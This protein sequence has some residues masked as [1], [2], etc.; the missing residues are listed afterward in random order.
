M[1]QVRKVSVNS[2]DRTH[3][4]PRYAADDEVAPAGQD[5]FGHDAVV[6]YIFGARDEGA[7]L[8]RDHDARLR[9][10]SK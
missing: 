4:G 7:C 2:R 3:R 1:G 9:S 5:R 8:L 10:P 6:R